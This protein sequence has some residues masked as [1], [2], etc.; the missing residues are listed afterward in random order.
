[1]VAVKLSV[2]IG[3]D[4]RVTIQLPDDVPVGS[5]DLEVNVHSLKTTVEGT[6][7]TSSVEL[8]TG[9]RDRQDASAAR[10]Q[11][12]AAG[13]IRASVD[14]PEGAKRLTLEERLRIGKLPQGA[15]PSEEL[16][17]QDRGEW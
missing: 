13:I 14:V 4:R 10:E 15:T 12:L 1:M 8:E 2:Y 11:L 9:I 6:S 17:S 3:E 7:T 5:A 16:V